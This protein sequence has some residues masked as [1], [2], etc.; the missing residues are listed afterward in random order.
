MTEEMIDACPYLSKM[1]QK[2]REAFIQKSLSRFIVF[3]KKN[4][5]ATIDINRLFKNYSERVPNS[6]CGHCNDN[7]TT[8]FCPLCPKQSK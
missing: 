8:P 1:E 5:V 6:G 4:D 7:L 3:L 2:A